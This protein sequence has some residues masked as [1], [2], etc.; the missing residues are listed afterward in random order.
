MSCFCFWCIMQLHF[1][2]KIFKLHCIGKIFKLHRIGKIFKLHRIGKILKWYWTIGVMMNFL[3]VL[4]KKQLWNKSCISWFDKWIGASFQSMKIKNKQQLKQSLLSIEREYIINTTFH[5][6]SLIVY[7][8][9]ISIWEYLSYIFSLLSLKCDETL[10]HVAWQC[11]RNN[12]GQILHLQKI[13]QI[14]LFLTTCN[15]SSTW[16]KITI[17]QSELWMWPHG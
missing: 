15:I 9:R 10:L 17:K 16:K 7:W 6:C 2:G 12:I 3:E 1:I 8:F 5:S 13:P 11:H 14:W 4:Q